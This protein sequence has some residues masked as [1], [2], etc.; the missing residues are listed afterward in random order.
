[1]ALPTIAALALTTA[2]CARPLAR[3]LAST[4]RSLASNRSRGVFVAA[5]C[6]PVAAAR[7]GTMVWYARNAT[8]VWNAYIGNGRCRGKPLLAPY[9]GNRGPSGITADGRYVLLTTAVGWEKTLPMSSPGEGSQNEI[10]LY[11]R[12]T[13]RLST[14]LPGATAS[15]RGVIWPTF[16]ADATKIVWSQMLETASESPPNGQWA[17]HV[18]DVNLETG[19]ISNNVEWQDPDGKP[20]FYEAYGW[21]PNSNRLI[22]MS[23]T[24]ST[25]TAPFRSS[26][27]FTLPEELN[28]NTPP[29]RISPKF[30]PVWPWQSHVDVFHEFAH[31]AP[32][33]PNLLYTSIGANAVGDDLYT[34][35]LESQQRD[36]LLGQPTRIS[37]FGGDL[38]ANLATRAVSGWPKPTYTVVTTMAWVN[39]AWVIA[40]C[41]RIL[42]SSVSAWRIQ[43]DG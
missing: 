1:M 12:R 26:Q 27:L 6:A 21:I 15:Q 22:F 35:N 3:S 29:T 16:N 9:D 18:A 24:R 25:D 7:N 19:T 20:A 32:N 41:P 33:N 36:G 38:D 2:G 5:N 11:D 28:P 8:G 13:G 34:Y 31:F 43:R 37:Y 42:C 23:N 39:G 10:Q 14:L 30:A 4:A 17:L 40:T